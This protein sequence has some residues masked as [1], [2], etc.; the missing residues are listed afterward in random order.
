MNIKNPMAMIISPKITPKACKF[1]KKGTSVVACVPNPK[2]SAKPD[3][4]LITKPVAINRNP[5]SAGMDF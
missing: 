1:P 2:T 5:I 4:K 3:V